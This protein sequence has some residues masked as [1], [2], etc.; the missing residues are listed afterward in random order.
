VAD[1]SV[2]ELND[3]MLSQSQSQ[4]FCSEFIVP[5]GNVRFRKAEERSAVRDGSSLSSIF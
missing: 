2:A 3:R 5:S 1:L 4:K